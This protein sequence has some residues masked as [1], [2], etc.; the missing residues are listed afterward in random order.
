MPR[1]KGK[2]S[3]PS[4]SSDA[5]TPEPG[6]ADAGAATL[7]S[8]PRGDRRRVIRAVAIFVVTMGLFYGL[9]HNPSRRWDI[10]IDYHQ[11]IASVSGS[12]LSVFGFEA[13]VE[14]TIITTVS[15]PFSVGIVQGCDAIEPSAAFL[16]AVIASPIQL[17]AK[18]IGAIVGTVVLLTINLF[19]I[20]SLILIGMYAPSALDVMHEDVWQAVFIA[21]A[22]GAWA[23]WVQWA[24]RRAEAPGGGAPT[25]SS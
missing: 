14:G 2:T 19:R 18:F 3:D 9:V 21:L 12:I 1:R 13:S 22:I 16:A 11:A 23:Y 6:I 17:S 10:L 15:P 8:K 5:A 20:V 7:S 24:S 25:K 4:A